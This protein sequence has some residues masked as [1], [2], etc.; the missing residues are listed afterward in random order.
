M[1]PTRYVAAALLVAGLAGHAHAERKIEIVTRPE[2]S[3]GNKLLLAGLAGGGAIAGGIGV[4][5][6][7]ESRDAANA[8]A[9]D[10]FTSMAWTPEDQANVDRAEDNRGKAAIAYG[11]GG[12]L[13]V[14][15]IVTLIV[16]EP[17]AETIVIT[18][19]RPMPIVAP[20]EGGAL[21]GGRWSF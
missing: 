1:I 8:V 19:N 9:A 2:R 20:A 18:P 7:L 17:K 14:A 13:L 11:I 10:S 5:F 4:Y 21:L 6:H 12:G 15:A 16:T 3:L